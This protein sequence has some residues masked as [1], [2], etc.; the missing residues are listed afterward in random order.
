MS[1]FFHNGGKARNDVFRFFKKDLTVKSTR[2]NSGVLIHSAH[3]H[4][5]EQAISL[6]QACAVHDHGGGVALKD[7]VFAIYSTAALPSH[8]HKTL[9]RESDLILS[10][11]QAASNVAAA[12]PIYTAWESLPARELISLPCPLEQKNTLGQKPWFLINAAIGHEHCIIGQGS[13]V[14]TLLVV[15]RRPWCVLEIC[16]SSSSVTIAAVLDFALLVKGF[17]AAGYDTAVYL[18]THEL[19][20]RE[21]TEHGIWSPSKPYKSRASIADLRDVCSAVFV[22][23]TRSYNSFWICLICV[24]GVELNLPLSTIVRALSDDAVGTRPFDRELGTG[25]PPRET[26]FNDIN[27]KALPYLGPRQGGRSWSAVNI[28]HTARSSS[29]TSDATANL[30]AVYSTALKKLTDM[31]T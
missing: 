3:G 28:I 29:D 19:Q 2:R 15:L 30:V 8:W 21:L 23:S 17:D 27:E 11:R 5:R 13:V 9:E 12:L 22:P 20:R 4:R 6:L 24:C 25:Q 31:A 7:D 16:C 18:L 10:L 14:E 26:D 1:R